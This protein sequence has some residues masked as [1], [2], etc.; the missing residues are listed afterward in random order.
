MGTDM[1]AEPITLYTG[2]ERRRAEDRITEARLR[3]LEEQMADIAVVMRDAVTAGLRDAVAD[4]QLWDA[5]GKAMRQQAQSAAGGWLLGGV[6]ALGKRLAW[7]VAIA[8]GVYALG[9][10]SALA[11]L[12]KAQAAGQ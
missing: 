11:A 2:P 9:G 7:I 5:A 6:G 12:I 10:W 3:H 8:A 1:P 4:P